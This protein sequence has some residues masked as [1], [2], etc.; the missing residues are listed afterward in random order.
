MGGYVVYHGM[1]RAPV[2]KDSYFLDVFLL[3]TNNTRDFT[4]GSY[5]TADSLGPC[6][7]LCVV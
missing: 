1:Y 7:N 3:S 6:L 4:L 5:L 2:G